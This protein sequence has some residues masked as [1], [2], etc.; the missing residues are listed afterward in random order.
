MATE[1][2]FPENLSGVD[3]II[4]TRWLVKV[5]DTV[6]PGDI[7]L[8]A[9]TDKVDTEVPAT[10][11]GVILQLNYSD[12]EILPANPL[13]GIVG[14]PGEAVVES[15]VAASA[16]TAAPSSAPAAE[17]APEVPPATPVARR[18]AE[19]LGVDLSGVEGSGPRGQVTKDRKSTH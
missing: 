9:A 16:E 11:G 17:T 8:E 15:A 7:L 1:L 3:G 14:Q 18:M 4:V 2:R 12:G 5:G 6:Q 13:L 10:V 19:Q